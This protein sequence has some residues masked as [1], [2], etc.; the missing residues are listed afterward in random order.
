MEKYNVDLFVNNVRFLLNEAQWSKGDFE[1]TVGVSTGYLSNIERAKS[2]PSVNFLLGISSLFGVS[3]NALLLSDL[4]ERSAFNT[5][6]QTFIQKLYK[7]TMAKKLEWVTE[8]SS[9]LLCK[10]SEN[11]PLLQ[12]D[13][14]KARK[15][16][17]EV[18]LEKE[19]YYYQME[20]GIYVC[21]LLVDDTEELWMT[22]PNG[23]NNYIC[24]GETD[25]ILAIALQT[26]Y[27]T[28]KNRILLPR[29]IIQAIDKF[30]EEP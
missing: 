28:V 30:I 27:K 20:N 2:K 26:L 5:K 25:A 23:T 24:S 29:T 18:K 15:S 8:S 19:W 13:V 6:M 14:I 1:R 11:R 7:N 4:Q 3:I 21:L 9:S 17:N 10:G 12:L 16:K 22:E